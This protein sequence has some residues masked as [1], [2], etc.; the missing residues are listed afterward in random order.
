MTPDTDIIQGLQ[1]SWAAIDA[2]LSGLPADRWELPTDCPGWDVQAVVAHLLGFESQWYLG[3]SAGG[4]A[5]GT[6]AHV[7]NALGADNEAWVVTRA[8]RSPTEVQAEYREVLSARM[9]Q[10]RGAAFDMEAVSTTWRGQEVLRDQLATRLVDVWV[11]EQDIRRAVGVPGGWDTIGARHTIE[12]MMG[13]VPD[14]LGRKA[15]LADGST[16]AVTLFGTN[17]RTVTAT[18]DGGRGRLI[19]AAERAPTAAL[20]MHEETFVCVTTGRRSAASYL[21]AKKITLRG[22]TDLARRVAEQLAI[23]DV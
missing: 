10:L 4:Q 1:D 9:D 22:D 18:V 2:V 21:E 17:A 11:H 7:L 8:G 19:S 12:R 20:T 14:V 15:R 23:I 16:V 6:E 13:A 3:R 5:T